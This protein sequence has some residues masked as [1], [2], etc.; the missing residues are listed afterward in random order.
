MTDEIPGC[1]E[2][3][4]GSS[5]FDKILALLSVGRSAFYIALFTSSAITQG[6]A[7]EGDPVYQGHRLWGSSSKK[8]NITGPNLSTCR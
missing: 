3:S 6:T 4:S 5:M 1:Q 8:Q 2:C 7:W